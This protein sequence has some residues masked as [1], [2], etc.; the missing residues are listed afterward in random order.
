MFFYIVVKGVSGPHFL[1]QA[2][3]FKSSPFLEIQDAPTFYKCISWKQKNWMN[4]RNI[5]LLLEIFIYVAVTITVIC[6]IKIETVMRI[7]QSR[8]CHLYN[9]NRD[10][11]LHNYNENCHPHICYS[12]CYLHICCWKFYLHEY[13]RN[14][15]LHN[16]NWTSELA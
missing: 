12:N 13:N 6:R 15:H 4:L 11:H 7:M 9:F 8:K 16:N 1:Y 3:F 14:C 10:P 2:Q 5:K